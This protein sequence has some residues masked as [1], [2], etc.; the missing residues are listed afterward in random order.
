MQVGGELLDGAGRGCGGFVADGVGD[1]VVA[2]LELVDL[3]SQ[4]GDAGAG[5]GVVHGAV[6]EG[7]EVAVDRGLLV[8]D[9]SLEGAGFGVPVSVA[10][11]VPRLGA[12]DG[13]GDEGGGLGVEAGEGV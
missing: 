1:L 2:C 4:G 9:L 12:G 10:V 13:V 8:L 3:S 7:G 5:S 11:A 6:L